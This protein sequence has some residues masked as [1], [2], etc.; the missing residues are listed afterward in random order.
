MKKAIAFI[1]LSLLMVAPAL[2]ETSIWVAKT[3][4]SV[5]YIG[6]A[7]HILR[8][9]DRPF[10][11]E[12]DKA[13]N[14]SEILIFETDFDKLGSPETQ[15]A[16][17]A[18]S[19][20]TDGQTLDSVISAEAFKKLD[21]LCTELGLSLASM[22][23]LKPSIIMVT[24]AMLKLQKLGVN[25]EGIDTYYHNKAKTD[26][27]SIEKLET[28]DEQIEAITSM[29]EGNE[30]AFVLYSIND[31]DKIEVLFDEMVKAW[32]TGN[33]TILYDLFLK[34]LKQDFPKLFKVMFLDREM[35]W[36]PKIEKY[37][38]TPKTEFVLV[39]TGHLIGKEGVIAQL[40]K[41]GYK[42]EKFK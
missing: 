26:K 29:G 8:E 7:I 35:N 11:P 24:L 19:V 37:L 9:S 28:I 10:P 3:D 42:V 2:C 23:Q 36:I 16:I 17:M 30:S 12:F 39:G 5:M 4:T 27:K 40:K 20:Y 15:Q 14:A 34:E 25:Q 31:M 32:K 38:I 13:Y 6:G 33:E 41:L 1:I 22:N 21:E 18:K